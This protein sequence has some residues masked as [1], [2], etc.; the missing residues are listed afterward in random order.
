MRILI[1]GATGFIGRRLARKL[2][3]DHRIIAL[4]R[5]KS[6]AKEVL[7]PGTKILVGDILDRNSLSVLKKE[8]FDIVYHLAAEL[9]ESSDK[10]WE[11]N[12]DGLRNVLEAVKK[13]GIKRFIYLSSIGVL[14]ETKEP[15]TEDHPYNPDTR[16]EESKAEAERIIMNFWLKYKIPY[17]IIRST[18]I[19][20]PNNIWAQIIKAAGKGVPIIGSG[21]NFFHLIYVDDVISA[22]T[23]ALSPVAENKVYNIAGP[24]VKT[25]EETYTLITRL[26]GSKQP[27]SRIPVSLAIGLAKV[28]EILGTS[29]VTAKS[30]S[31][32]RLIRNRIVDWSLINKDLGWK[33]RYSLEDGMKKTITEL[34]KRG[35]I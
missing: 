29:D 18:I 7:P 16:Y 31:I 27:S 2:S 12:V 34:K 35:M 14:G 15:A 4:V 6:R 13:K 20:G 30:S 33:P 17:T 32:K 10:L 11:T 24:D 19:Y 28:K 21:K 22:L 9:D 1:T 23:L 25:Y 26:L 5:D 8:K 3:R